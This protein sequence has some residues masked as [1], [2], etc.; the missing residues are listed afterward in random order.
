[1]PTIRAE[2]T[3]TARPSEAGPP[4][5][6]PVVGLTTFDKVF[7][8]GGLVATSVVQMVSVLGAGGPLAYVA[9]ERVE[10]SLEGRSGAF[11]L[12]HVG[13]IEDGVPSLE[14]HVVPGSAVG[15]LSGLSGAGSIEHTATGAHLALDYTLPG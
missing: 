15:G 12:L 5:D 6:A 3:V 10:G 2:F 14:L 9:L 13:S 8:D 11:V 4:G 1:M 7:A